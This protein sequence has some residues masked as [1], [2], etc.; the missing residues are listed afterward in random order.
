[1]LLFHEHNLFISFVIFFSV[2][3]SLII[4]KIKHETPKVI[5]SE[6]YILTNYVLFIK[7]PLKTNVMNY[8][9]HFIE[10]TDKSN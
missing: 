10:L 6:T 9:F 8:S 4:W 1:M 2:F 5:F 3:T 7:Y